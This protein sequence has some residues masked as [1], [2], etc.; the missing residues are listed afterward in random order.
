VS[1][2][3]GCSRHANVFT[4]SVASLA[5][6]ASAKFAITVKATAAGKALVLAAAASQNPDPHPLNNISIQQITIK[7]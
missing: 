2:T 6:G 1:C 4:W 7:H 3:S 5:S